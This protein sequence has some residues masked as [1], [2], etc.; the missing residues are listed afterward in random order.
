[1]NKYYFAAK[2]QQEYSEIICEK[3]IS[4]GV[5]DENI[6]ISRKACNFLEI[7]IYIKFYDINTYQK[8]NAWDVPGIIEKW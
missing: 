6:L 7:G 8:C 5:P 1:M 3:A 2:I 4:L